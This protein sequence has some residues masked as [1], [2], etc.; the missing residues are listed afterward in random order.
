MELL[1]NQILCILLF[2]GVSFV[3]GSA[4]IFIGD[5]L[6]LSSSK[7][8]GK[9][10]RRA[11]VLAFLLN[12]GGGVLMGLSFCHWL[13]TT[14]E[15]K[16]NTD[17]QWRSMILVMLSK[18]LSGLESIQAKTPLPVVEIL[19]CTGFFLICALEVVVEYL[20]GI[21][22][23]GPGGGHGHSHSGVAHPNIAEGSSNLVNKNTVN[24]QLQHQFVS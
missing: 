18:N 3:I 12:Y 20:L 23:G 6:K 7:A 22:G 5:R 24:V 1:G 21:N 16:C 8:G 9:A 19:M 4:P 13:P 15:G 2:V 17:A 10:N 14:R 11:K